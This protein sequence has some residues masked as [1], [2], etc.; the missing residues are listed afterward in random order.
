MK[1]YNADNYF[2]SIK[3]TIDDQTLEDIT[4]AIP[5]VKKILGIKSAEATKVSAGGDPTTLS[6]CESFKSVIA[7]RRFDINELGW[8]QELQAFVDGHIGCQQQ[9]CGQP[10]CIQQD[11]VQYESYSG[12]GS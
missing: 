4:A 3:S 1:Q 9:P 2:G 10:E 8:E 7:Y 6:K 12:S 11:A 5:N